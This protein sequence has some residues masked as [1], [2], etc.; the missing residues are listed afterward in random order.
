[1][2]GEPL[3]SLNG[4]IIEAVAAR[5][6]PFDRG[7]LWGDGVYEV[8]PCFGGELYR[9]DEHI[10]RLF[11]SL[12]YVRIDPGMT[13]QEMLSATEALL[14]A[15]RERL[16]PNSMY[17]V[18][19]WI[20]RGVDSESMAALAAGPATVMIFFRP[21]DTAAIARNHAQ[22][23]R[24]SVTTTRRNPPAC[25]ETRA[26]VT[27]KMNQILAELD[28]AARGALS[29]MLDLDGN[30]AE[31]AVANIFIA[32]DGVLWTPP[33]RNILEGVTRKVVFEL[34]ERLGIP[35]EERLFTQYDLAQADEYFITSSAICATPVASI[36]DFTPTHPVPGPI[37]TQLIDA[38]AVDTGYDFRDQQS[39]A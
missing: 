22:G 33:E 26:K 4:E 1:M 9:L 14:E 17:R 37:T 30:V 19:H 12:R 38:F 21:V 20:T 35:L 11:R 29:L 24:L 18:G 36:D 5:I 8:T 23:V 34:C 39:T 13:P 16:A 25:V 6:S 3:L 15:N 28:A 2:S 31:N 27:S 10:D 32:R 7:F